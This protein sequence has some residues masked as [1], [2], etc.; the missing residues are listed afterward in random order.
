MIDFISS[1]Q[2]NTE[3]EWLINFISIETVPNI[4]HHAIQSVIKNPPFTI[5]TPESVLNDI[6]IVKRIWNLMNTDSAFDYQFRTDL[7]SFY[8]AL[9]GNNP[10]ACVPQI[11]PRPSAGEKR[12]ITERSVSVSF[13]S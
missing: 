6:T 2:S 12:S 3:L 4:R 11:H 10:P 7:I 8:F 1:T 5:R 13:Q 9:W